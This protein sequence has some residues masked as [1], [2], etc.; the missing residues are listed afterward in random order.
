MSDGPAPGPIRVVIA[1]D[2]R[3]VREGLVM[4]V[5]FFDGIE[6]V[7]TASN[8]QEA[9]D[10]AVACTPDVVLMDRRMPGLDGVAAT[11]RLREL[12]PSAPSWY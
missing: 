12:L 6:V 8:G 11:R 1:D 7:S 10:V 9:V 3:V 5:G 2:Q 4:L